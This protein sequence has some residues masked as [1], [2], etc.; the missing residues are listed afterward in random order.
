[1][2]IHWKPQETPPA[3]DQ[4]RRRAAFLPIRCITW[5]FDRFFRG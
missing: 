4:K 2:A 3:L 1:L 5:A